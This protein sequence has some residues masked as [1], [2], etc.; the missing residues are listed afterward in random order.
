M[1]SRSRCEID[2]I[3]YTMGLSEPVRARVEES[4][5]VQL[6]TV[7]AKLLT[8]SKTMYVA[9]IVMSVLAGVRPSTS[10]TFQ[11][12]IVVLAFWA[13]GIAD[14]L[15]TKN[16]LEK[17]SHIGLRDYIAEYLSDFRMDWY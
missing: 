10:G 14:A 12:M 16:G 1:L 4:G 5:H 11:I 15:V 6:S 7:E 3:A 8:H 9:L 17:N 13:G 2:N